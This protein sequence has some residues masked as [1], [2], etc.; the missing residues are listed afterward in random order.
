MSSSW[1]SVGLAS[2]ATC[3]YCS[4]AA[5]VIGVSGLV[6]PLILKK[7]RLAVFIQLLAKLEKDAPLPAL[8]IEFRPAYHQPVSVA[9]HSRLLSSVKVIISQLVEE[10]LQMADLCLQIEDVQGGQVV[11]LSGHADLGVCPELREVWIA[12]ERMLRSFFLRFGHG[13]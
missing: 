2:W 10:L 12:R 6:G 3:E 9:L 4:N 1:A 5:S 8:L 11:E 7:D 13:M